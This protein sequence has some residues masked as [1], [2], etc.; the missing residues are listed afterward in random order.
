[1]SLK[2][3]LEQ[4][5]KLWTEKHGITYPFEKD[6]FVNFIKSQITEAY[7]KGFVD[8]GIDGFNCGRK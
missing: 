5:E 8:G 3:Q 4:S 6:V 1:M 7:K 2:E